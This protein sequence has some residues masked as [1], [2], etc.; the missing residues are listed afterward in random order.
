MAVKA[1]VVA[2][3]L[4]QAARKANEH[5]HIAVDESARIWFTH[6]VIVGET[7]QAVRDTFNNGEWM[8]WTKAN[9][10][11]TI[12]MANGYMRV[13]AF[14]DSPAVQNA[15]TY[16]EAVQKLRWMPIRAQHTRTVTPETAE[17][18]RQMHE[19]GQS[20]RAIGKQFNTSGQI[21]K[22][23]AV[24]GER[25]DKRKR[26]RLSQAKNYRENRDKERAEQNKEMTKYGGDLNL[27]Y[28]NVRRAQGYLAKLDIN[29]FV[30]DNELSQA[31][32][33]LRRAE[34]RL[35]AAMKKGRKSG[36]R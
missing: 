14:K 25:E 3:D 21:V 20:L 30:G 15:G 31:G 12:R 13:A 6:A 1:E 17:Q 8:K 24:P 29:E 2:V 4:A 7:L 22:Y 34:D 27:A 35:V 5:H 33:W 18:M 11:F 19:Q 16:S 36:N 26:N 10:D 32:V 9:L 23:W 28:K